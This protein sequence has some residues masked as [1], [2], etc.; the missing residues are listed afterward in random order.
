MAA[1]WLPY[2]ISIVS[3]I[4]IAILKAGCLFSSE[5]IDLPTY[6]LIR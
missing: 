4:G 3:L 5:Y 1:A 2:Y 6:N